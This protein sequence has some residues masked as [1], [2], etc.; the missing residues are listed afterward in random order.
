MTLCISDTARRTITVYANPL[1]YTY[2][3]GNCLPADRSASL[4]AMP[5]TP[6]GQTI[7]GYQWNFGD[8]TG[9]TTDKDP[10]IQLCR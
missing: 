6:D 1:D 4:H 5:L 8:G 9:T 3:P 2:L 7:S 10:A